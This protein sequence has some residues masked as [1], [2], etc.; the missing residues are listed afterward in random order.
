MINK[1]ILLLKKD[2]SR[3]KTKEIAGTISILNAVQSLLKN[4]INL[5]MLS[6]HARAFG[7]W[8]KGMHK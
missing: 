7:E 3:V 2:R 8:P 4:L 6:A 5:Y 1:K